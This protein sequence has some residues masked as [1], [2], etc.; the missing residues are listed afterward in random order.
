MKD[1]IIHFLLTY[2]YPLYDGICEDIKTG[3]VRLW[4]YL[5]YKLIDKLGGH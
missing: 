4:N 5:R 3:R 1:R 2:P